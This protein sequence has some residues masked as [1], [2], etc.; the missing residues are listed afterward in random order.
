MSLAPPVAAG[1]FEGAVSGGD[2]EWIDGE[3]FSGAARG[4]IDGLFPRL[5][6]KWNRYE[7]FGGVMG[8]EAASRGAKQA[9]MV[10][11]DASTFK[12]LR[13]NA[14]QLQATQ[15]ELKLMDAITFINM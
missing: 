8:F 14:D 10:E 13:A 1:D 9:V 12:V 7:F 2:G 5:R 6:I 11:A 3:N 4:F 15:V